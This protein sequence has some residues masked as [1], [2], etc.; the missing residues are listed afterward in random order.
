MSA[1][2]LILA[3]IGVLAGVVASLLGLGGGL[4]MTPFL[5]GLGMPLTQVVPTSTC[6]IAGTALLTGILNW[7]QRAGGDLRLAAVTTLAMLPMLEASTWINRWLRTL[8]SRWA[9]GL[10]GG[11]FIL[12]MLW[13]LL[14]V[15][16]PGKPMSAG[17]PW[18]GPGIRLGSGNRCSL[19]RLGLGGSA[20]GLM[21]GLL[22]IGG[23]RVL[24]PL[25][26]GPL[27][28]AIKAA[29]ATSSLCILFSACYSAASFASKGLVDTS[30][31]GWLLCGS[32]PGA[33]LG[34]LALA[35]VD[36]QRLRQTFAGLS[37]AALAAIALA[38]FG[39]H[40]IALT[41]LIGACI[42]VGWVALRTVLSPLPPLSLKES[43]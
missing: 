7:R 37:I 26:S 8:P 24:V 38:Q 42:W 5:A 9:D 22:G 12:M 27:G 14:A 32:L 11:L 21:G 28:L 10:I 15:L 18:P 29:I 19:L 25:F 17:D 1:D 30:T 2:P 23:G 35:R 39:Q 16:R 40:V 36:Q 33:W 13:S 31:A 6:A 34:T 43:A 20:A 4:L 3:G 41:L